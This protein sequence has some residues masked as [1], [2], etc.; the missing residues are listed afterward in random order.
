MWRTS[1]YFWVCSRKVGMLW[2]I[3]LCHPK[4]KMTLLLKGQFTQKWKWLSPLKGAVHPKMKITHHIKG[5]VHPKMKILSSFT[6]PQVGPN[7][8]KCVYSEHKGRILKNERNSSI[9]FILWKSMVLQNSLI[10]NF[11]QN[12]HLCVQ[13]KHRFGP[14]WGWVNNDRIFIFGW[15][16]PLSWG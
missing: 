5:A 7:L 15:T 14:T 11:L 4:M 2:D 10:T 9:F 16:V 8:Y 12:I 3:I 13:N 1:T 6:H